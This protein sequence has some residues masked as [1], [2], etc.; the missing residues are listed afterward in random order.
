MPERP[1]AELAAI[2]PRFAAVRGSH[3]HA[4]PCAGCGADFIKQ[5]Q[6]TSLRLK[7][8]RVPTGIILVLALGAGGHFYGRGPAA[9]D[10]PRNTDTYVIVLLTRASKPGGDEASF[11]FRECRG[12]ALRRGP[13]F[14]RV[15]VAGGQQAALPRMCL[16]R[17]FGRGTHTGSS[18][19]DEERFHFNYFISI[20]FGASWST[21]AA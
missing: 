12:V 11:V 15:N 14:Q 3:Q 8:H 18:E 4:P 2:A 19:E 16:G 17:Q 5:H 1:L 13:V 6:R 21:R 7:E 20:V 9:V 10:P